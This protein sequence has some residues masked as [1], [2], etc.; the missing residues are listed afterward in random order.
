MTKSTT[1]SNTTQ[2]LSQRIDRI[3]DF[4]PKVK[5]RKLDNGAVQ[6]NSIIVKNKRGSWLCDNENFF[7]RKSAVGYAL[8][9]IRND[10][11]KATAIKKLDKELQKYK[12]DIDFYHYHLRRSKNVRATI[13]ENR[14]SRDMP[15]LYRADS[16][17]TQLLKTVEV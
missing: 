9:L 8:C 11:A 17:L 12:T 15:Y 3:L 10:H 6:V 14:I 16:K 4:N 2:I 5:I 7:R 1:K 13:M